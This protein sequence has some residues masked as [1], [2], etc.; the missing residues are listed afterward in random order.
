MH[1]CKSKEIAV[2]VTVTATRHHWHPPYNVRLAFH[3]PK[4]ATQFHPSVHLASVSAGRAALAP[5]S[6][7][8][9]VGKYKEEQVHHPIFN[10]RP[11]ERRGP[12]VVIYSE[13]LAQ[14]KHEL[15]NI[16]DFPEPP[17]SV[18]SLT[19]ELFHVAA[20]IY[21]SEDDRG[22]QIYKYLE[23]LLGVELVRY[24]KSIGKSNKMATEA[25]AIV[26]Q[27]IPF[28]S[29]NIKKAVVAYVEL[30]NELGVRGDGGLQGALSFRKYVAGKDVKL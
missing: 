8:A 23:R 5:S 6:V 7:T 12:P 21:P 29:E 2:T 27:N 25:D 10:G 16:T 17:P 28:G 9:S 11:F 24:V 26:L 18:I 13:S 1:L 14:L 30:K 22:Q 15:R 3:Y 19:A 4:S 20:T